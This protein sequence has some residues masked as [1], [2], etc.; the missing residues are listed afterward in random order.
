VFRLRRSV[1][2]DNNATTPVARAVRKRV[3]RV[4]RDHYGNPSALYHHGRSSAVLLQASRRTVAEAINASPD[5]ITFVGSATEANNNV[6]KMCR[7][8]ARQ[9]RGKIVASA[10]EHASVLESLDYLGQQGLQVVRLGV[11]PEGRVDPAQLEQRVDSDTALVCVMLAN[12]EIGTIQDIGAICEVAH[13][14]GAYV[15]SDCVQALGKIPVD[16]AALGVDY[17]SFSAHKIHGPKGVGAL[18][19]RTGSPHLPFIH[20]GHQEQG[21]RAGTEGLHNIA[22]FAEACRAVPSLLHKAGSIATLKEHFLERLRQLEPRVGVNSPA[23]GCLPNT[24]NILFPDHSNAQVIAALDHYGVSV[25]AGSA[26][27]TSSDKPSHVLTALGLSTS[28]AR[29]CVRISLCSKTSKRDID[30][31]V[32]VL[33]D[34]LA[35]ATPAI[36][37][38][39]AG[40]VDAGIIFDPDTFILDIR[41]WH[42][43][44]MFRSLPNAHEISFLGAKKYFHHVPKD[45]HILVVCQNGPNAPFVAHQLKARGYTRVSTVLT[46]LSGWRLAQPELYSKHA[47]ENVLRLDPR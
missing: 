10:I 29:Q 45:K 44:K 1:Y 34:Y 17:A 35:G 38:F 30:Y 31:A 6:L 11:S 9:G 40:Q 7:E 14:A 26:C 28:Q 2:L 3:A 18:Y 39:P 27:D 15:L 13:A 23:S 12:N 42:Q 25:A 47:G 8:L 33:R 37:V 21:L 43:R 36:N 24:I 22:G 19:V 4:L 5:E 20:G 32:G 41:L 46:G 16:V